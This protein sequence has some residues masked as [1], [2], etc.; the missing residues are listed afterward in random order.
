L[1]NNSG[2]TW[3]GKWSDFPEKEGW[4]RVMN[5]NVKSIFYLTAALSPL[6]AK[7]A[8]NLA[9]GRVINISSIAGISPRTEESKLAN[10]GDGLWS[11]NVS[12]A[13]G[14]AFYPLREHTMVDIT[15]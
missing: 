4:D 7:D 13:C 8:T 11:Y 5:L 2:A 10:D 15:L 9:P 1:V 14:I 6:L 12:K 3:G